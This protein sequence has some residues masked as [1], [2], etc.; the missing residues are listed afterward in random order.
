MPH[1]Y[2]VGFAVSGRGHLFRSAVLQ[3]ETL[4]ITP[5]ILV[6]EERSPAD[7]DHFCMQ[8]GV[9]CVR[10]PTNRTALQERIY[11]TCVAENLDLLCLT[12]DKI[13][14]PELVSLY[15]ER[16]INVHMSFLPAFP[17]REGLAQTLRGGVRYAGATIHEVDEKVDHGAIIAQCIT[18]I[19]PNDTVNSLGA[20]LFGLLRLMY[21]QVIA[22]Y[23]SGRILKDDQ[24]KILVR[25]AVYGE[26]PISP[27][28]ELAFTD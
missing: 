15:R 5:A 17:G 7:L 10:L 27:S 16:I 22:W 3:R 13:I 14:Q 24:G 4:G 1:E 28:V 23:A 19:R 26:F 21:L 9:R 6:A 2:R 12:F 25:D 8:H 20:R 18:G 11:E